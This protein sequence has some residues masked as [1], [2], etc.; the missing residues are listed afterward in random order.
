VRRVL[1]T[2]IDRHNVCT[3][4]LVPG[5]PRRE[6]QR[7]IIEVIVQPDLRIGGDAQGGH[8]LDVNSERRPDGEDAGEVKARNT[9]LEDGDFA[10]VEGAL[11]EL[12]M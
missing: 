7:D 4:L 5:T 10:C 12:N 1:L 3:T 8:T 9:G 11:D 6:N 2:S